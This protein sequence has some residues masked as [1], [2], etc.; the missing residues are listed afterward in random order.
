MPNALD[1]FS[2]GNEI[3]SVVEV[4]SV[5]KG[6]RSSKAVGNDNKHGEVY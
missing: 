5:D 3:L 4:S 1:T 2:A 6:R